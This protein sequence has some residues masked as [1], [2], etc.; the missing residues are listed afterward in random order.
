MTEGADH[1]AERASFSCVAAYPPIDSFAFLADGQSAALVGR[2]GAVEWLCAPRFDGASVFAR[3]LDRARGGALE[4]T[5]EGAP[6][7]A[8]RYL[9]G[10]LVLESRYESES[11]SAVVLDFMALEAEGRHGRGEVDPFCALVRLVRCERGEARVR[12]R[13]AARPDY[14]R[15]EAGWSEMGGFFTAE[16]PGSRLWVSSD[17]HLSRAGTDLQASFVLREGDSASFA[18]RYAGDPTTPM[19]V[20]RAEELLEITCSSWRAWSSRCKYEGV[21]RELVLRSA[22]VLKGLV[23]HASGA[24]LA[25]PTTSLPERVGGERNWDYRYTWL[26]DAALTLLALMQ[27][28]YEHEAGDY[29]D[30]LLQEF[31]RCGDEPHLVLGINGEHHL[32]ERTLDHLEGYACSHPVRIGNGAHDQFQLG[33]YGSLLG[34]ALIYQQRTGALTTDHWRLLH[35]LVEFTVR[36]WREPDNGIWEVRSERRHFTNSK[37]MAWVCV[38]R[39][40]QLAELMG[41][42]DGPLDRWRQA[43][44]EIRA[45]VL[46][47]GYDHERGTFVQS[48]GDTALDASALRFPLVEFIPGDDPRMVSTIDRIID[49]LETS[50]GLVLRYVQ[51]HVDDGL[52]GGEGS[53]AICSFWLV[54]ALVRADRQAEAERRFTAL[55]DR[56]SDL[57]LYA[58]ELSAEGMLGNFPQAFTHLAMIQ[59][60]ADVQAGRDS[61][62]PRRGDGRTAVRG[63]PLRAGRSARLSIRG[64]QAG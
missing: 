59:A 40:I 50:E 58:E 60:A 20:A 42:D 43:R 31:I 5:V 56:A 41:I 19:S 16:V 53:F 55:C 28:G 4:L 25:A 63:R 17:R 34:A 33:T 22:L 15:S 7:P 9:D 52:A 27:L 14:G 38:D 51:D 62:V 12:A 21:G 13:V 10:T 23:Y 1:G 29:M 61:R 8:R 32:A 48:Y 64:R 47:H 44:A 39:G 46:E 37:V 11:G 49:E 35:A 2:D 3:L 26:R 45:D 54:S 57:G 24:L 6:L 18:F 30:F 36:H